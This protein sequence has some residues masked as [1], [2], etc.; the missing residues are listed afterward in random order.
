MKLLRKS[1]KKLPGFWSAYLNTFQSSPSG[2]I[3]DL[4]FVVLD[5]ETTGFDLGRD[6]IL[7]IG[8]V[9]L[10]GNTI[11]VNK[12]L[13]IYIKQEHYDRESAEIHCIIKDERRPCVSEEEALKFF[14]EYIGS[15]VLV[16]HHANFDISMI[17]NALKRN[18]LPSL[19]NK[20]L[21]TGVLYKKTLL[22]SPLLERRESYSLDHLADKFNIS[23]KDRHTALGDAYIT[24]I[25]LLKILSFFDGRTK[26]SVEALMEA[27]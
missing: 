5:T 6:R 12:S 19:M 24:A 3:E 10:I 11:E 25:A 20:V 14:L 18:G 27:K 9:C 21:D 1:K 23:K 2:S 7:C 17:N 8:A 13:E 26:K 22:N 15:A 4:R 16:A